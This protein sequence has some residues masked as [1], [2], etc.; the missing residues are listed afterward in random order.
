MS[1]NLAGKEPIVAR[2]PI[3]RTRLEHADQTVV[4]VPDEDRAGRALA[5]SRLCNPQTPG[6]F[7]SARVF[8][9]PAERNAAI[10]QIEN[11]RYSHPRL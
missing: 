11:L 10:Q 6:P 7:Q 5:V 1:G 4:R 9:S 3:L 8:P 2:K